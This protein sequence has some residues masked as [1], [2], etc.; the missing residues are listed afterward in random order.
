M[1]RRPS[2][3]S[4]VDPAELH[5]ERSFEF[6]TT[7]LRRARKRRA[8]ILEVGCGRGQLARRLAAAGH[9]VTAIDR[10][11]DAVRAARRIGVPARVADF[12]E[13]DGGPFDAVVCVLSLHHVGALARAVRN[14]ER[15]LVPGGLLIA[16]EFGRERIDRASARWFYGA[17]DLLDMAGL[18]RHED[19][20]PYRGPKRGAAANRHGPSHADTAAEPL[21]RWRNRHVHARAIHTG[22]AMERAIAN[23]FEIVSAEPGP[24]LFRYAGRRLQRGARGARIVRRLLEAELDG[25]AAGLLRA[26]GI[27]IVARRRS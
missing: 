2:T 19:P 21:E 10:S 23:R 3:P 18:T 6:V 27:R 12:L 17:L 24:H 26:T 4:A 13:Y 15:L 25:M 20:G 16:D 22:R 7:A 1:S 5:A 8:D 11:A 14:A 9:R